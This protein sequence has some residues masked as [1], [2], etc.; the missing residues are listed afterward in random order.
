MSNILQVGDNIVKRKKNRDLLNELVIGHAF[1]L[2][3]S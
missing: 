2:S 3:L 1:M